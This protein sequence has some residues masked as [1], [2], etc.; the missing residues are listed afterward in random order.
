MDQKELKKKMKEINDKIQDDFINDLH[1][2]ITHYNNK[3]NK[4]DYNLT[5]NEQK[6]V[7]EIYHMIKWIYE[8]C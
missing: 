2:R 5:L 3:V 7:T 8:N 1:D 6:K 4:K